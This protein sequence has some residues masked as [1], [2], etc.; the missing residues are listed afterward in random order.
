M[1][2]LTSLSLG[3]MKH[4]LALSRVQTANGIGSKVRKEEMNEI[5]Q[6][7]PKVSLVSLYN[8]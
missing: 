3:K 8:L 5:H 7:R 4:R 1:S 6:G 2:G